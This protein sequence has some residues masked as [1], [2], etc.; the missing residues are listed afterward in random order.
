MQNCWSV[1][2]ARSHD[3]NCKDVDGIE[4]RTG[5]RGTYLLPIG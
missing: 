4:Y 3:I 1:D 2:F 5:G